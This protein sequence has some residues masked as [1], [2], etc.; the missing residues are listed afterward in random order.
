MRAPRGFYVGFLACVFLVSGA[1]D[2][3]IA[4]AEE[5]PQDMLAARVRVQG[6]ACDK[7]LLGATRD[8]KR[9]RPDSAV[10]I[11]KCRNATFRI[12]STPDM[13]AKIERLR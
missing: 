9:S 10:W 2:G 1:S 8:A 6:F 5:T 3:R 7:P 4:A 11:L 12:R 13:P